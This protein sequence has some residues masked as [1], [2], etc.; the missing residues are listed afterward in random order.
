METIKFDDIEKLRSKVGSEYS[1]WSQQVEVTQDTLPGKDGV[2]APPVWA[3]GMEVQVVAATCA[4]VEAPAP[5]LGPPR[6]TATNTTNAA[7]ETMAEWP[8]SLAIT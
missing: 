6:G 2:V 7:L 4:V 5:E 1:G 8:S 3:L